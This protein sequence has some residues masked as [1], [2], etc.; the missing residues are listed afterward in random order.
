MMVS[1]PARHTQQRSIYQPD[2]RQTPR[3]PVMDIGLISFDTTT[4][5]RLSL[6]F[7]AVRSPCPSPF[8]TTCHLTFMM[9]RLCAILTGVNPPP[10]AFLWGGG[11]R[12]RI[13]PE[14][15]ARTEKN[16][17]MRVRGKGKKSACFMCASTHYSHLCNTDHIK[18][19]GGA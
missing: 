15:W 18:P 12:M 19:K 11:G 13:T 8:V 10:P 4:S 3:T 6:H 16:F 9:A 5:P 14:T 2:G 7:V 1:S 17:V